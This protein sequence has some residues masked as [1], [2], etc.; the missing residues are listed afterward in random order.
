MTRWPIIDASLTFNV[1]PPSAVLSTQIQ[2]TEGASPNQ[3]INYWSILDPCPLSHS[4]RVRFQSHQSQ[5]IPE[6]I[7]LLRPVRRWHHGKKIILLMQRELLIM[8]T[9]L[10]KINWNSTKS[11][12]PYKNWRMN[13]KMSSRK[14][15]ATMMHTAPSPAKP[16]SCQISSNGR[17]IFT[18]YAM[19]IK[20]ASTV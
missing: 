12:K 11:K 8:T 5:L 18:K 13:S 9:C 14:P 16:N 6:K 15:L 17:R 7:F 20:R 10:R 2:T 4:A 1:N 19:Q 3:K